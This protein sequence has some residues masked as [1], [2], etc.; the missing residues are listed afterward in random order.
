MRRL[1]S[2]S[3]TF[4][5]LVAWACAGPDSTRQQHA[6][7]DAVYAA[8]M[9]SASDYNAI[10]ETKALAICV[11]WPKSPDQPIYVDTAGGMYVPQTSDGLLPVP[12]AALE[13]CRD[14]RDKGGYD[15]ECTILD[16]NG[17]NRLRVP[18]FVRGASGIKSRAKRAREGAAARRPAPRAAAKRT[19]PPRP[20]DHGGI[21]S[22]DQSAGHEN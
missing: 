20:V 21:T 7:A 14:N 15:C 17:Q 4:A 6:I 8:V 19:K 22:A 16:A 2:I 10:A 13:H 5:V 3:V 11:Q 1:Q 9:E 12:V 18:E